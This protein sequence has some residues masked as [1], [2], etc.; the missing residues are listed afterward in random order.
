VVLRMIKK[1]VLF[2]C[3]A[4]VL[5]IAGCTQNGFNYGHYNR[6]MRRNYSNADEQHAIAAA[7]GLNYTQLLNISRWYGNYN[8]ALTGD[9]SSHWPY[10]I[11]TTVIEDYNS[12]YNRARSHQDPID[13]SFTYHANVRTFAS[14]DL[15]L[16]LGNR[17][18][19]WPWYNM[20]VN[21]NPVNSVFDDQVTKGVK[22][23][24]GVNA[25]SIMANG[26]RGVPISANSTLSYKDVYYVEFYLSYGATWGPKAA[27]GVGMAQVV[28][29]DKALH[30]LFIIVFDGG[31]VVS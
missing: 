16:T 11:D 6:D 22:N 9:D 1:A 25:S 10:F 5:L 19:G 31:H 21:G 18:N 13:I 30:P 12:S 20:S 24:E 4:C 7:E 2:V 29:M 23:F 3:I 14:L 26:T 27:F 17:W 15:G 28:V 8:S